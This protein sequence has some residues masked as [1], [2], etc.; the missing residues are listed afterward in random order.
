MKIIT[1]IA[2]FILLVSLVAFS[3]GCTHVV[4]PKE[5][6]A[7]GLDVVGPMQAGYSVNLVNNQPETTPKL[8]AAR[9]A[10]TFLANYNEWTQFYIDQFSTELTKRN[11]T[12]SGE[13]P[14]VMKVALSKIGIRR[15]KV[16]QG[17]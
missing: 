4:N 9:G 14:N 11:V 12:V 2:C 1:K 6:P 7:I 13:S 8:F 3:G 16:V 15:R 5:T 17:V 10:H